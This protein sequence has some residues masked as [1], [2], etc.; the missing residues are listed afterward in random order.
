MIK[1]AT[2]YRFKCDG[3][4]AEMLEPALVSAEFVECGVTQ[5]KSSG[6]IPPREEHGAFV[7][8]INGQYILK[9]MTEVR[10]VPAQA[11]AKRLDEMAKHYEDQTGRKPGK[12]IRR[13]LKDQ[14]L[15]DLLP[16]AFTSASST[17][18]WIAPKLGLIVIDATGSKADDIVTG[19]VKAT[20]G[21]AVHLVMTEMTPSAAMAHWLGTGEA[22]YKFSIDRECEL[23]SCDELKSIVKYGR[24]PLDIDQVR[25]HITQ[26]KVPTKL[27]LTWRD[28]FSFVLTD[29]MQIKKISFLDVVFNESSA[30][31]STA[32]E[33]FDADVAIMTGELSELLPDL[34]EALGGELTVGAL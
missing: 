15:L 29:S 23:R 27:A 8:V 14:A 3:L 1:Q 16:Q 33:A 5:Q 12:K 17:L 9:V 6:F 20:D 18:V 10:K 11:I 28:R 31:T 13:E 34:L 19:L 22:P 24:H 25:E 30:R 7:E 2:I 32:N 4:N 26:G 21:L